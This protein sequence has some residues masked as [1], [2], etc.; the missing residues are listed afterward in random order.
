MRPSAG[1]WQDP[2]AGQA[3][4][5]VVCM[6]FRGDELT[7]LHYCSKG[8]ELLGG[9]LQASDA[10]GG[11]LVVG[12]ARPVV[13]KRTGGDAPISRT[14]PRSRQRFTLETGPMW[15]LR[16]ERS[17]DGLLSHA[18]GKLAAP[19]WEPPDEALNAA[20]RYEDPS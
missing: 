20:D 15:L 17:L 10:A 14:S 4:E 18:Q 6:V 3:D 2:W 16:A 5:D 1:S 7:Y 19:G 13:V 12:T 8:T 9:P 11:W